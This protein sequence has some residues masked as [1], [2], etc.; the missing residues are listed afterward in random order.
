M[1]D[2]TQNTLANSWQKTLTNQWTQSK[3]ATTGP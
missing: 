2:E 1:I 3:A